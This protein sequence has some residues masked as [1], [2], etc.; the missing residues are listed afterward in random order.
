[1]IQ[2]ISMLCSVLVLQRFAD[3]CC[4]SCSLFNQGADPGLYQTPKPLASPT[5]KPKQ[6]TESHRIIRIEHCTAFLIEIFE[7][8]IF[9]SSRGNKTIR[10]NVKHDTAIVKN[11]SQPDHGTTSAGKP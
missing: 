1:M 8:H 3:V 2:C 7:I 6:N 10:N 5:K 9:H 11:L 4:Q